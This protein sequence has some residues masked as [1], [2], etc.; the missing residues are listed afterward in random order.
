MEPTPGI[1]PTQFE[2]RTTRKMIIT[3]GK[4]LLPDLDPPPATVSHK[5]AKNSNITSNKPCIRFGI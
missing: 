5:L 2:K 1:I 3:R 4:N